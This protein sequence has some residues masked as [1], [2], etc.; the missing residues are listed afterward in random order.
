MEEC[1]IIEEKGETEEK[2]IY[3]PI[4]IGQNDSKYML[5]IETEEDKITF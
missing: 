5:N 2:T 1:Q 3:E 4:I